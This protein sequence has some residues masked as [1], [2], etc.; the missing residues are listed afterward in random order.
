[1]KRL[2]KLAVKVIMLISKEKRIETKT[3]YILM[4]LV[5]LAYYLLVLLLF[6]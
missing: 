1:M 4:L 6:I 2:L 5:F 3:V